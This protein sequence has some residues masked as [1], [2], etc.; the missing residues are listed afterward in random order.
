MKILSGDRRTKLT[1]RKSETPE[2]C[3]FH[4]NQRKTWRFNNGGEDNGR[5][6]DRVKKKNLQRTGKSIK[7]FIC[8]KIEREE[9]NGRIMEE[10][11]LEGKK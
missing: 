8:K 2:A 7:N 9:L 3:S 11:R 1:S 6:E 4:C 10:N 5:R